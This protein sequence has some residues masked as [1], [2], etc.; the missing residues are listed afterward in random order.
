M[1][2]ELPPIL[3]YYRFRGQLQ[4]IRTLF[5]YLEIPFLE[6]HL[7]HLEEQKKSLSPVIINHVLKFKL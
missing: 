4:P 3:V 1:L 6:I 2:K 5:C 7:D